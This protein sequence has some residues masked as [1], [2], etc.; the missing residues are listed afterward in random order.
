[1]ALALRTV[2]RPPVGCMA[3]STHLFFTPPYVS[4]VPNEPPRIRRHWPSWWVARLG[5]STE[6]LLYP[7]A[8]TA[9]VYCMCVP[10]RMYCMLI[11][12][13]VST[14]CMCHVRAP[15]ARTAC[16]PDQSGACS[17]T[18]MYRTVRTA[19]YSSLIDLAGWVL[20]AKMIM[21]APCSDA[22]MPDII[23]T[24][25]HAVHIVHAV[26]AEALR[27]PRV[28][29]VPRA[30]VL[31]VRTACT[32]SCLR[33]LVA[34]HAQG[35]L[36]NRGTACTACTACTALHAPA[37]GHCG[38]LVAMMKSLPGTSVVEVIMATRYFI[39]KFIF[40]TNLL[41]CF[42]ALAAGSGGKPPSSTLYRV[43][44]IYHMYH[45]HVPHRARQMEIRRLRCVVR[46]KAVL[47][48]SGRS[49]LQAATSLS[50]PR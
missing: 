11:P 34:M 50:L 44:R 14:V 13:Y 35:H 9:C 23:F 33:A 37:S 12:P 28:R 49:W 25:R 36:C 17:S 10:C 39:F 29:C 32:C 5:E 3:W 7:T 47:S 26:H 1:L 18:C 27:V 6:P 4:H 21:C 15:H 43:Y 45:T 24:T 16:Q 38:S 20:G 22:S 8:C 46:T 40:H 42:A 31:H 19:A 48:S 41:M 30:C 2:P